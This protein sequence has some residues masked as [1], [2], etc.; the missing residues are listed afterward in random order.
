MAQQV[1]VNFLPEFKFLEP[2]FLNL[3]KED[4]DIT[5]EI[6]QKAYNDCISFLRQRGI[7]S[8]SKWSDKSYTVFIGDVVQQNKF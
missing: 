2:V 1:R 6:I 4:G 8:I 5:E 7:V 3:P